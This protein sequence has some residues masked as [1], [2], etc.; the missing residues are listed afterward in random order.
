MN[1]Q[2]LMARYCQKLQSKSTRTILR[3]VVQPK[4]K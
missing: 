2:F 3:G 1:F 4:R